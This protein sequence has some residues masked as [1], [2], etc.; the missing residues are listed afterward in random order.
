M[1]TSRRYL[2][3]LGVLLIYYC[4][5][6]PGF[7]QEQVPERTPPTATSGQVEI[8]AIRI[9]RIEA[10][11]ASPEADLTNMQ[12]S[13]WIDVKDAK[14]RTFLVRLVKLEPIVDDMGKVL[15]TDDRR[16]DILP[17]AKEVLA[18]ELKTSRDRNGPVV[19]LW[20]DAPS[21]GASQL[22]SLKGRFKVTPAGTETLE[23]ENLPSIVGK[24]VKHKLL[25]ETNV[26]VKSIEWGDYSTDVTLEVT[27]Q[28]DRLINWTVAQDGQPLTPASLSKSAAGDLVQIS[29]KGFRRLRPNENTSLLI[30]VATVGEKQVIDFEFTDIDLP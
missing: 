7:A 29:G 26:M 22:K 30:T 25:T 5:C 24:Q 4:N 3:Y 9:T 2:F 20:L 17:L 14:A 18:S 27:G 1:L 21:R 28:H 15:S 16:R 13:M 23:L 11:D 6:T 12:L 8:D 19:S 10:S